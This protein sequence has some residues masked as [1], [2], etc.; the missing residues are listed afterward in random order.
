MAAS[1]TRIQ[2]PLNLDRMLKGRL[3]IY[4]LNYCPLR[5]RDIGRHRKHWNE[6]GKGGEK[7]KS[8]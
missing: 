1:I 5:R 2:S 7:N 8:H 3:L 6:A 4:V